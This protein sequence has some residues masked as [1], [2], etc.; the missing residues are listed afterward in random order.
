MSLTDFISKHF[1]F[2]NNSFSLGFLITFFFCSNIQYKC[3][4]CRNNHKFNFYFSS[5]MHGLV[6]GLKNEE[7]IKQKNLSRLVSIT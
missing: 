4:R 6:H 7:I 1:S 3:D 2:S 5:W